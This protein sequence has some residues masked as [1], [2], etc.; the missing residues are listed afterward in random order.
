MEAFCGLLSDSAEDFASTWL[1]DGAPRLQELQ[2]TT[3]VAAAAAGATTAAAA[4]AATTAA[5]AANP[6]PPAAAGANS[7]ASDEILD[8]ALCKNYQAPAVDPRSRQYRRQPRSTDTPT[9]P[10]HP[11]TDARV[12]PVGFARMCANPMRASRAAAPPKL[13]CISREGR[14][15]FGFA[16]RT[17]SPA[18]ASTFCRSASSRS[19]SRR[20]YSC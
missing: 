4:A 14:S 11:R 8:P 18:R 1:R 15:G 5:A 10:V 13:W 3:T 12:R 16:A 7:S 17:T 6:A 20:S 9:S 2:A 19:H